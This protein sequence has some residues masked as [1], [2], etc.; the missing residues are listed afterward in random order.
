MMIR[1]LSPLKSNK[2]RIK[3]ARQSALEVD[4]SIIDSLDFQCI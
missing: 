2:L 1:S 4:L 3:E